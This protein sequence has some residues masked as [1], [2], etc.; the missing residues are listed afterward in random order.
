MELQQ[1]PL[2]AEYIDKLGW[3]IVRTDGARMFYRHIPLMGGLLK[4]QRPPHLPRISKL[5]PILKENRVRT[6]A[7]EPHPKEDLRKYK[8]WCA[9]VAKHCALVRSSYQPTKTILIATDIPEEDM[10]KKFS[11]AKRRAVRKAVKYGVTVEESQDIR[12]LIGIKNKSSGPFGFITTFGIDRF[13]PIMA[14]NHATVLLAY[15]SGHKLVG[16]I[17]LVFWEKTAY[18][19]I[20]G[21]TKEGKK[22][23]APTLLVFEA[24][25]VARRRGMKRFDFVGVWDERMK[26]QHHDWLGFTKFK[27]GFGGEPFYYP[28]F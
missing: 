18:Y 1:S 23:S 8:R 20:A 11:E 25:K 3:K 9:T 21:A 27:E 26:N 2:Y 16:G 19:W 13:W 28:V 7:I 5:L 10:F 15:T 24:L 14:P 4:I 22:L 6:V 12:R 17:L